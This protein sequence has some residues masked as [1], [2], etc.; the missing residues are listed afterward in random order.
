MPLIFLREDIT[1]LEVD[2]IVNSANPEASIGGGVDLAIHQAGG[3]ELVNARIALGPIRVTEVKVTLAFNLAAK[4]VIHVVGPR[5]Q[6]G[7]K[8]EKRLLLNAYINALKEA[9]QL[10]CNSVAFPL[11]SAG[12][13]AFPRDIA[14]K[15]AINAIQKFLDDYDMTVYLTLLGNKKQMNHDELIAYLQKKYPIYRPTP[16]TGGKTKV[17][18]ASSFRPVNTFED[19]KK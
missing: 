14:L 9:A 10:G 18:R 19:E 12:V 8:S 1:K 3:E 2:A 7:M 11:I 5:W 17:F 16:F 13:F 15:T 4:Y 6:G